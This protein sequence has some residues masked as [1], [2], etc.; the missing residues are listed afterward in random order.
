MSAPIKTEFIFRAAI[1]GLIVL[2]GIGMGLIGMCLYR[3]IPIDSALSA[4]VGGLVTSITAI[5]SSIGG[6]RK[7]DSPPTNPTNN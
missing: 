6:G 4:I 7:E 1:I 5:L 2:A 3:D